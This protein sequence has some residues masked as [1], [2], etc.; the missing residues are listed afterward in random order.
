MAGFPSGNLIP[1]HL[2]V[3]FFALAD[4]S[5]ANAANDVWKDLGKRCSDAIKYR[6]ISPGDL[7]VAVEA[8]L[9]RMCGSA[10]PHAPFLL[11][12]DEL[13]KC[14]G[15]CTSAYQSDKK[16]PNA[17]AAFRSESC[18]LANVVNGRALVVS[19]DDELPTGETASSG[20]HAEEAVQLQPFPVA[21]MF[22]GVLL[23]LSAER[24]LHLNYEGRLARAGDDDGRSKIAERASALASIVGNVRFAI[25][26]RCALAAAGRGAELHELLKT[27]ARETNVV[28]TD[29]WKLRRD[30][31]VIVAHALREENVLSSA[32]LPGGSSWDARRGDGYIQGMG[33]PQFRVKLPL[34][35]LWALTAAQAKDRPLFVG[36]HNMTRKVGNR[37]AWQAWEV[38][39]VNL[40][41]VLPRARKLI[42]NARVESLRQHFGSVSLF[43]EEL[44]SIVMN[45]D[46]NPVAVSARELPAL[47]LLYLAQD[48]SLTSCVWRLPPNNAGMDSV[49]FFVDER[50]EMGIMCHQLKQ[51][52]VDVNNPL[53]WGETCKI[54]KKMLGHLAVAAWLAT[55]ATCSRQASDRAMSFKDLHALWAVMDDVCDALAD[56]PVDTSTDAALSDLLTAHW[57]RV[58]NKT[59]DFNDVLCGVSL[60]LG[61]AVFVVATQRPRGADFEKDRVNKPDRTMGSVVLLAK[62]DLPG[63]VGSFLSPIVDDCGC[64]ANTSMSEEIDVLGS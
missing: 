48:F 12:V 21:K 34:Y 29:V 64:I 50:N 47:L 1:L 6:T 15:F 41:L 27:A 45:A 13:N 46:F 17:V 11:V 42:A 55:V 3:L 10:A 18:R 26:L 63:H 32:L 8:L 53:P 19:L 16:R 24:D 39:W 58:P 62:S 2:R 30:G 61:R 59:V 31:E 4:F 49:R 60:V 36:L 7:Q 56:K 22:E 9:Q 23:E 57:H 38:I 14:S 33:G 5:D 51:T 40:E 35:A 52:S 28:C 54:V 37:M 20:R 44:R 25:Y 43:G